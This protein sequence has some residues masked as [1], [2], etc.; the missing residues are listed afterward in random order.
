LEALPGKS[1]ENKWQM[2]RGDADAAIPKHSDHAVHFLEANVKHA[3]VFDRC[4]ENQ[5]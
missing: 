4:P 1:L 2:L 3:G 5:K